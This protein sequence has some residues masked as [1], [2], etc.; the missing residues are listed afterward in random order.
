MNILNQTISLYR[1]AFE[2][3]NIKLETNWTRGSRFQV[4]ADQDRMGQLYANLLTNSLRYTEEN[5]KLEINVRQ[6]KKSVEIEFND[7]MPAVSDE[8]MTRLFD[9]LFR[10]ESSRS[11][12]TGGTGL[13]LA[14]CK[15][16]VEAHQGQISA[17][18]SAFGGLQIKIELPLAYR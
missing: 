6:K 17:T 4:L 2:L 16:I 15:N 8:D 12:V 11:R 7:S 1:E 5:G 3:K 14:I 13:G 18:K 10:V 9:R